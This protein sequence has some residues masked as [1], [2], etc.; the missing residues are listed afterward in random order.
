MKLTSETIVIV[1]FTNSLPHYNRNYAK[2]LTIQGIKVRKYKKLKWEN[3][4]NHN[5]LSYW[6]TSP[7]ICS[8][9]ARTCKISK[10]E[11]ARNRSEKTLELLKTNTSSPILSPIATVFSNYTSHSP[12]FSF[13]SKHYF[14]NPPPILSF[15]IISFFFFLFYLILMSKY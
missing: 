11:I 3:T 15:D 4:I 10:R 9:I 12:S 13:S 6:N 8:P 5:Y 2:V 14:Q 1:K 7:S